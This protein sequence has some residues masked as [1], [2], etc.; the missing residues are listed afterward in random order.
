MALSDMAARN[1]KATGKAYT[2]GDID[3][4]SLAVSP[5]GGKTWHYR[6]YWAGKQKRMSLGTYPEVGLREAR[7]LRDEARALLAKGINPR[8]DRKQKRQAVR[9]ADENTFQAI[10]DKWGEH[11]RLVLKEGRQS[12][13]SQ[14]LRVFTND[15]L[16]ALGKRPIYEIQ[17]PDLLD[18]IS[19]IEKRKAL[20]IAEKVRTWLRQMFRYALIVVPG[21]QQN[22]A[23][24]LDVVAMPLPPVRHNPFLRMDE[25]PAMLLRLRKYHGRLQT[26][27]GVRFL[28]LTG[29]RTGEL[30]LATPDQFHLDQGLW[31]IPPEIVKQLQLELRKEGK[32]PGD[33]PPYIV[34][35]SA[36][37]IEIVRYQLEQFKPAQ[38]YL[39]THCWDL[40][41]RMSEN[42]LNHALKRMGY[43]E[44]LTGHGI[45]ATI[46]TALNEIGYPKIWVDA[47]LSHSDPDK[48][49]SA[50]NHA[51]YVEQRR[52][53][54]QD[55]ADRL[56]LFEQLQVE[57]ASMHLTVHLEGVPEVP[58][59][60]PENAQAPAA[61]FPIVLV[62]KPGAGMPIIPES[63]HRLSAITGP[64]TQPVLSDSQRERL[65][66]VDIYKSPH[67]VSAADY[68]T[69]AGRS[70]RWI[71]Y[72]IS[73]RN[74]L[75]LGL[76]NLGHRI[77]EWHFDPLKHKLIQTV[78][79]HAQDADPWDVYRALVAPH[80]MLKGGSPIEAVTS[81]NF[82]EAVMATCLTLSGR[83]T[84]SLQGI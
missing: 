50:Y 12:T 72:E 32:R 74:V 28:L 67:L 52:R 54:M 9:L 64:K 77:P 46:S 53:M 82:H 35:L 29:V 13:L 41:K 20:S 14:I 39:F 22:P 38:R 48:V 69:M 79:K 8:A 10:F 18:V 5:T 36:Q 27:L 6:Y 15:V 76:G 51:E 56:D 2:L 80:R 66:M 23:F 11:R 21:L 26:Q 45:R 44:Q 25:L 78:L 68:A 24:D 75:A 34:P 31:I 63:V 47:Q 61:P 1:A 49:S 55:W 65:E 60:V 59:T 30:R 57:A 40:K 83:E 58:E 19:K 62:S 71:T 70:R 42:T 37:A 81:D 84:P 7:G 16:P 73:R 4:L 43:D 33:I 17:R 3:G